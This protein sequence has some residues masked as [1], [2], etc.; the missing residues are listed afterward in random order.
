VHIVY[1][2]GTGF[3]KTYQVEVKDGEDTLLEEQ[4]RDCEPPDP[5]TTGKIV[6]TICGAEI[7]GQPGEPLA[8]VR[9]YVVQQID[10]YTFEDETTPE[11]TFTIAGIPT[12]QAGLQVRAERGG[13]AY[14]WDDV[15]VSSINVAPDGTDLTISLDCQPLEPDDE[16]SYLVVNGTF[17][18]IGNVL[19]RMGLD[20]TRAEGV[21]ADITTLWTSEVFANYDQLDNYDAVFVNCG[22]S[23]VDF[24]L[25]L[26]PGI[27]QN[28]RDYVE[29]GGSLYVSDWAYD[30]IEAVWPD[31]INFLRDDDEND[32]AEFGEDGDYTVEVVEPGL[33]DYIG[34]DTVNIGFTFGNFVLISDIG[35]GVTTY[36]RG[37]MQYRINDGISTL[38]DA[39]V[40]VGFS[41]G[42]GR[43]IFTTFHQE[44]N[45]DGQVET[46]DGP[47]DLVLRY[48]VFSL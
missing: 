29:G 8:G 21:P 22:I 23:E 41:V 38:T 10:G 33:A 25:G 9:V 40:T 32:G 17:D 36:L 26:S 47:E 18:K 44:T 1:V 24:D 14:Q 48:L 35:P 37:D 31:K 19:D 20:Y 15:N 11:G 46:L 7:D 30:L 34:S 13:F 3:Q 4:V 12:P 45:E 43:V 42:L 16:R 39:P 5:G 27:A 6:G 2:Q 28:I